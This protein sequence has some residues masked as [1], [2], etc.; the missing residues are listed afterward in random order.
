LAKKLYYLSMRD[1]QWKPVPSYNSTCGFP[2]WRGFGALK[3]SILDS[4]SAK[5]Y[6][7]GNQFSGFSENWELFYLKTFIHH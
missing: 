6:K 2:Q 4:G 5:L 1:G 7:V 3:Y